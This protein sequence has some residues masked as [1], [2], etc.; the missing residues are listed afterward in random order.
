MYRHLGIACITCT[1]IQIVSNTWCAKMTVHPELV[2]PRLAA[3]VLYSTPFA[4][5]YAR[6][7][8][9]EIFRYKPFLAELPADEGSPEWCLRPQAIPREVSKPIF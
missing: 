2:L 6:W 3:E 7:L 9:T 1:F 5:G 4:R 8:L